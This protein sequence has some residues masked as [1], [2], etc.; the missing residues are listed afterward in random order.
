MNANDWKFKS[1]PNIPFVV[2]GTSIL[3][4][5]GMAKL[6]KPSTHDL[7]L[8]WSPFDRKEHMGWKHEDHRY[9]LQME[10][11]GKA[12]IVRYNWV[13]IK[14]I[15]RDNYDNYIRRMLI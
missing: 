8:T 7:P 9:S 11:K 12:I 5:D 10:N 4:K 2:S 3:L 14:I 6:V 1:F 15:K 13:W